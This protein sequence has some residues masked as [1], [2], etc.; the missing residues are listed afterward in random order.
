MLNHFTPGAPKWTHTV[1]TDAFSAKISVQQDRIYV[2]VSVYQ[3][4]SEVP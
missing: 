3:K 1:H 4:L 2:C